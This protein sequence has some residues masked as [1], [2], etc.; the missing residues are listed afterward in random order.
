[1]IGKMQAL[2]QPSHMVVVWDGGLAAA[3]MDLLPAYK[4]QRPEMPSDLEQQLDE[5]VAYL[6]AANI[7]SVVGNGVE[8]DDCIALIA[9]QASDKGMKVIIASSDKDF[10]QLVSPQIGLLNPN[11]KS[12]SIWGIEQVQH[13]TGVNP[14]QIVDWLSLIGD[15]VDNIPGVPGVGPKTATDLLRQFGSV[16]ELFGR[17]EEVPSER[18]R[19]NL[20]AAAEAV[21]RNQ[22]LVRLNEN[23]PCDVPITAMSVRGGHYES[24]RELFSSWG[25]RTLQ[26]ELE[27]EHL[28]TAE[29][30]Q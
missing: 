21:R 22:E 8:A 25:F 29:L 15:A 4:A 11:D 9:R 19:T 2:V 5:I 1:M 23:V 18:L 20:R 12:D 14:T 16:H 7:A 13:K 30:F 10:M 24:L 17:L 28:K 26:Q 27:Q 6:K 3:R